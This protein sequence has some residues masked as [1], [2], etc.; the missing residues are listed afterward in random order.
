M[1][2]EQELGDETFR[3]AYKIVQVSGHILLHTLSA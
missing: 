2:L 1:N 3:K